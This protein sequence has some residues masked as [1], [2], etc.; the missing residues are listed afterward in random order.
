MMWLTT[1]TCCLWQHPASG[2]G[3]QVQLKMQA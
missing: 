2:V 1:L 3:L